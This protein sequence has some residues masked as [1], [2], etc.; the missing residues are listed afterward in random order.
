MATSA[1]APNRTVARNGAPGPTVWESY[2]TV[3]QI[4][5]PGA[6]DPG[7]WNAGPGGTARL[8]FNVKAPRELQIIN[9]P[10]PENE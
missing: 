6:A 1:H 2:K 10:E 7:P 9:E 5:L 3:E 8:S 4:F